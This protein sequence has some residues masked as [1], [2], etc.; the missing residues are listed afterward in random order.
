MGALL[1]IA[2]KSHA[3]AEAHHALI[4][5]FL[6]MKPTQSAL[7]NAHREAELTVARARLAQEKLCM[8]RYHNLRAKD[9]ELA[10]KTHE[11]VQAFNINLAATKTFL[12]KILKIRY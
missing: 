1:G 4:T 7:A 8:G 9:L 12:A 5:N 6:A 11:E 3:A 2:E 10:K